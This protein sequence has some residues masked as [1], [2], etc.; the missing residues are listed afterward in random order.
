MSTASLVRYACRLVDRRTDRPGGVEV[1][2]AR[3]C[4]LPDRP[5]Q[6]ISKKFAREV[7]KRRTR[8]RGPYSA[9]MSAYTAKRVR[10]E[11][12]VSLLLFAPLIPIQNVQKKKTSSSRSTGNITYPLRDNCRK[13]HVGTF[14]SGRYRTPFEA[15]TIKEKN[16]SALTPPLLPGSVSE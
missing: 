9:T 10:V 2:K 11:S 14:G 6:L 7:E 16:H 15:N 12:C 8:R 1:Q 13:T 3:A 4:Q 5:N